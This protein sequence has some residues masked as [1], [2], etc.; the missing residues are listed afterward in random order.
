MY[1]QKMK[2]SYTKY[3]SYF[4]FIIRFSRHKIILSNC[5]KSLIS[6]LP[7][8]GLGTK[9]NGSILDPTLRNAVVDGRD[10]KQK[11]LAGFLLYSKK[12]L[13]FC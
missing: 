13:N 6:V 2:K 1:Y 3:K 12:I 10:F 4:S 11:E 9:V 7:H 8:Y 5:Y